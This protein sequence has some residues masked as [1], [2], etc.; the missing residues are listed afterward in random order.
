MSSR[1]GAPAAYAME[2]E[3]TPGAVASAVGIGK[4]PMS[5]GHTDLPVAA[6]CL[7]VVALAATD[8]PTVSASLFA[9]VPPDLG[10]SVVMLPAT[11]ERH[12]RLLHVDP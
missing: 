9:T 6:A 8:C 5:A 1:F 3:A 10:L 4:P 7:A 12:H 11:F 2:A